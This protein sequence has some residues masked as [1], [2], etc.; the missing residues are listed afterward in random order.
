M[1]N[2]KDDWAERK[3]YGSKC[4]LWSGATNGNGYGR[5]YVGKGKSLMAHRVIHEGVFGKIPEGL[6]L[7]HLCRNRSCVNPLHLEI[8]TN[9][10]NVLRGVGIPA[11]N[12]RKTTCVK[13]HSNFR[14]YPYGRECITCKALRRKNEYKKEKGVKWTCVCGTTILKANKIRHLRS[15]D[16]LKAIRSIAVERNK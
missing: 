11:Q 10:E 5:V 9:G 7:D 2:K 15:Y 6:V 16:C 14:I 1:S 8:V 12:K 4:I 3:L 13:G